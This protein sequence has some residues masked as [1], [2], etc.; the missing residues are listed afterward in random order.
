MAEDPWYLKGFRR[1]RPAGPL[2]N[3]G[4]TL[5]HTSLFWALFLFFFPW[6]I[7]ALERALGLSAYHFPTQPWSPWVGFAI[8][9]ALGLL[10]GATM[11]LKGQGTPLPLDFPNKL[12]LSGPYLYVR[13]PM[14]IAGLSQAAFVGLYLGSWFVPLYALAGG[15][16][17]NLFARPPEEH[18]LEL[19]FGQAYKHYKAHTRCWIPRLR[20][21][22]APAEATSE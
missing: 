12:V 2:I 14:A 1:A 17:W 7:A 15:I 19:E 20:P 13:N 9:G 4:K 10:S 6:K 3:L 5:L 18:H 22:R 8:M 21:Y 11:A 16:I